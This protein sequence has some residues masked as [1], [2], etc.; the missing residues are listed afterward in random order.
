MG[1]WHILAEKGDATTAGMP[2]PWS[3][4][5]RLRTSTEHRCRRGLR[6]MQIHTLEPESPPTAPPRGKDCR[7]LFPLGAAAAAVPHC[8]GSGQHPP[9]RSAA[10]QMQWCLA[11]LQAAQS[12]PPKAP[13]HRLAQQH[14]HHLWCPSVMLWMAGAPIQSRSCI[15]TA[16]AHMQLFITF[17]QSNLRPQ[18][19]HVAPSG[20]SVCF[21]CTK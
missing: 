16:V 14:L 12:R 4:L 15:T 13:Q 5:A 17:K 19:A 11:D 9:A 10:V 2:R 21:A 8:L 7:Q 20:Q 1:H 6:R 3:V 18:Y